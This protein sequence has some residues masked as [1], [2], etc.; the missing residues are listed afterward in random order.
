MRQVL[1]LHCM[2]ASSAAWRGVQAALPAARLIC[3]DLPGHGRAAS[4]EGVPFMDVALELVLDAS[5]DGLFDVVGHSYGGCLALRLLVDHPGRVRSLT[6]VEPVMFAAADPGLQA[7]EARR[8]E[9]CDAALRAGDRDAAARV[10]TALWG[11]G[12]P[13][14]KVPERTRTAIRARIHLV[15]QS[16]PGIMEDVHDI[17]PRLPAGAPRVM[18]VTRTDPLPI[19]AG[20]AEGLAARLQGARVT[21]LGRGHMIPMEVPEALADMLNGFWTDVT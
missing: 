2:L 21:R 11:D 7:S 19:V 20:I 9:A 14:D 17:L 6:L 8:M 3:P 12:T 5:P 10:F 4:A 13:W 15:A 18:I 1:A 16:G